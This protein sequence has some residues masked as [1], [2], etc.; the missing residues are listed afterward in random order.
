MGGILDGAVNYMCK[1]EKLIEMHSTLCNLLFP[2]SHLLIFSQKEDEERKRKEE[3]DQRNAAG[4]G[5]SGG[6]GGKAKVRA[7][8]EF[9]NQ[10]GL[11]SVALGSKPVV[12]GYE[13]TQC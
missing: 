6:G 4:H 12:K 13:R 3:E 11:N 1:N 8:S 7:T 2:T 5:S 9:H 10:S